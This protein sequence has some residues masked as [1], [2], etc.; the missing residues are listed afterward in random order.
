MK[1]AGFFVLF[2]FAIF[3]SQYAH[4]PESFGHPEYQIPGCLR[5]FGVTAYS[6]DDDLV[7]ILV[8]AR[9]AIY[10]TGF[11]IAIKKDLYEAFKKALAEYK[12]IKKGPEEPEWV[13]VGNAAEEVG[14]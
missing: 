2:T 7:Q 1:K 4:N 10:S 3:C 5:D 8:R 6:S 14:A 11:E 9:L 13:M 12:K